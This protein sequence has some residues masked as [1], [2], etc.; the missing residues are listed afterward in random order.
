MLWNTL[1][2]NN[3]QLEKKNYLWRMATKQGMFLVWT[4]LRTSR[5]ASFVTVPSEIKLN[6]FMSQDI[7][8]S[9]LRSGR[10]NF[11]II[12][13][14]FLVWIT[15]HLFSTETSVSELE[16]AFQQFTNRSDIAIL[17]I[18][19]NVRSWF[20]FFKRLNQDSDKVLLLTMLL[21]WS[22][23]KVAWNCYI[24]QTNW[25]TAPQLFLLSVA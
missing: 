9:G 1:L 3:A 25:A 10:I 6:I 5:I 2:E 11:F 7:Y 13:Y 21:I 4:M 12:L 15:F 18:N 19:Q 22:L 23:E 24:P 14:L 20:F 17:L 8:F 16:E